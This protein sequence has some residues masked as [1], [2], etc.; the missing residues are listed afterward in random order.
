[1][2]FNLGLKSEKA[3]LELE[4]IKLRAERK[5]EKECLEL[6]GKLT[7]LKREIESLKTSRHE[8]DT[9]L[10]HDRKIADEDIKH[11]VK[12][13]EE[14]LDLEQ[15]KKIIVLQKESDVKIATVKDGYR[16][17]ME[18]RLKAETDQ[19]KEMYGQILERL[20]NINVK[21]HGKV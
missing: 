9:R 5:T 7:G 6:E 17:K 8:E 1:M 12:M 20:P 11:M 14:R 3:N 19:I 4:I 13:K 2:F 21:M 18:T 16:D 15:E 10:K